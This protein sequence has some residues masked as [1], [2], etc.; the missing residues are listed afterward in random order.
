M[1]IIFCICIAPFPSDAKGCCPYYYPVRKSSQ[2]F[3][4]TWDGSQLA[5]A[6]Y[7][8]LDCNIPHNQQ[9]PDMLWS[10]KQIEIK[11]LSQ[12]YKHTGRSGAQTH[13]IDDLVIMRLALF[14][15]TTL[16][17]KQSNRF[18]WTQDGNLLVPPPKK[19]KQAKVAN[20]M[21]N[22]FSLAW[23]L[24]YRYSKSMILQVNLIFLT[25]Y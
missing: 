13:N 17:L 10:T 25:A 4:F 23:V 11:Y 15:Q 2:T 5:N 8:H 21:F 24:M 6:S 12:G 1:I 7:H 20:I 16:A 18:H 22:D 9:V 3:G 19:K 14:R